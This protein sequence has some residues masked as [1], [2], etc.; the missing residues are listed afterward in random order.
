[1]DKIPSESS[2]TKSSILKRIGN[3]YWIFLILILVIAV[4]VFVLSPTQRIYNGLTL[5][6]EE[7]YSLLIPAGWNQELVEAG[8]MAYFN[9]ADFDTS[10]DAII[11][12]FSDKQIQGYVDYNDQEKEDLKLFLDTLIQSSLTNTSGNSHFENIETTPTT[13]PKADIA[14]TLALSGQN[15][16]NVQFKGEGLMIVTENGYFYFMLVGSQQDV[17]DREIEEIRKIV[18]GFDVTKL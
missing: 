3:R 11:V 13:H 2:T 10:D 8:Q 4:M 17:F 7:S 12:G 18:S 1:M 16:S 5:R 14:L 6:Q 15:Q 9:G